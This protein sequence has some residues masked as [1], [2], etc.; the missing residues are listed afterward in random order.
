MGFL[1]RNIERGR[2]LRERQRGLQIL[3]HL[4]SQPLGES[5]SLSLDLF[6]VSLDLR[7]S[8][9]LF[10]SLSGSLSDSGSE[11]EGDKYT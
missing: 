8:L 9:S 3:R 10:L 4:L 5:L 11:E 1:E 6:S 2:N 7:L